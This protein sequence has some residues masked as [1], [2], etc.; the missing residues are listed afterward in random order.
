MYFIIS[1][2]KIHTSSIAIWDQLFGIQ[3]P[4]SLLSGTP[5]GI[6]QDE[7]MVTTPALIGQYQSGM[8]LSNIGLGDGNVPVMWGFP[9]NDF[10]MLLR[11][12]LWPYFILNVEQAFA[13]SWNFS[14]FFFIISTFLLFMLLTRNNFW[15]SLFGALFIFLSGAMQWWSYWL[16]I[17]MIYLNGIVISFAYLL[18]SKNKKSLL[19][20]G[21][22]LLFCSYSF[23]IGTY[24]PWQ[25]PLVY[26]YLAIIIGFILRKKEFRSIKEKLFWRTGILFV[27]IAVLGIFLYHYY[28]LVKDTYNI[29]LNTVYPGRRFTNGGD[30]DKG[31]LFSEFF[32]MYLWDDHVPEKWMNICEASSF[33]M[34]FPVLFYCIG[35][36]YIKFKKT[37]WLQ[38]ML[39]FTIIVLLIWILAGFPPVLSK[40]SL[41]SM[42]PVKR[43][44]PI[45]GIANC[46]LLIC[47][48]GNK[49]PEQKIS[50]SRPELIILSVSIFI[51][52]IIT[53]NHINGATN[54]FFKPGQLSLLYVLVPLIYLL[55]RYKD[56]KYSKLI[57]AFVLLG[58]N[59]PNLKIHPVTS[60]LS[61][62]LENPVIMA[63]KEINE[64]DPDA[65]WAVFGSMRI[66]NLLKTNGIKVFNGVKT[67]P[68]LKDMAVLDS[69]GKNKFIYNRYAHI[70]MTMHIDWKDS[71]GF[72]LIDNI[73]QND[74]YS[75][76]MDPCSPKLKQLGIK[77]IVFTYKPQDVEIRCMTKIAE[78]N[79]IYVYKREEK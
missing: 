54:H 26:L 5:R 31:K 40:I 43:T 27:T 36:N 7:W 64:K 32:G 29:L 44:L 4:E 10:T 20:A 50:F 57:L 37:D 70:V 6:R 51:F 79:Q 33:M 62:L 15:I 35:Y 69:S 1:F 22:V 56:I 74:I 48:L 67:V 45:L 13:F 14:I 59:I 63:T 12:N 78:A 46:I 42:S 18:Y 25:V 39:S 11:P 65:R 21:F 76:Y 71:I 8:H 75:I 3:Q 66:A 17:Y 34:F 58:I 55:I 2:L 30:L 53:A 49:Q 72:K 47:W 16:G 41:L 24:P 28:G 77:Y 9:V 19:I 61:P 38:L 60:G 52:A 23:L 73:E 68:L